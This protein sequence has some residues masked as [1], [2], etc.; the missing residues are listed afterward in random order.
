MVRMAARAPGPDAIKI[1][2]ARLT[3]QQIIDNFADYIRDTRK[4]LAVRFHVHICHPLMYLQAIPGLVSLSC[5]AWSADNIDSYFDVNGHYMKETG[6][7]VERKWTLETR[8]ISF[9]NLAHHTGKHLGQALFKV[10][11]RVG[12]VSKVSGAVLG[13]LALLHST[14]V[15][16]V[17]S[18][19]PTVNDKMMEE[20]GRLITNA[21]GKEYDPVE[22][23]VRYATPLTAAMW[24][25]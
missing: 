22:H 20:F 12:I 9:I 1:P 7:G 17:T 11:E 13:D 3:R 15:G 19:N 10:C 8:I 21:T 2:N 16:Y 6:S 24:L 4:E 5:D 23:R 25:I 14:Q 18:D